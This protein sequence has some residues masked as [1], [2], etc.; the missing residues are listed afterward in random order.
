ME[1]VLLEA[2][3]MLT[4]GRM[5]LPPSLCLAALRGDDL[6]LQQLLKGGLDPNEADN[7]GR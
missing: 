6:L 7:S 2:E 4:R 1:E 3:N 5:E